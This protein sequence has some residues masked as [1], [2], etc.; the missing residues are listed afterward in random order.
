MTWNSHIG[1]RQES[2]L[3]SAPHSNMKGRRGHGS[4]LRAFY[5][6]PSR[7]CR[8]IRFPEP[9]PLG[10]FSAPMS[11]SP[12][13]TTGARLDFQTICS[14]PRVF[15]G[16]SHGQLPVPWPLEQASVVSSHVLTYGEEHVHLPAAAAPGLSGTLQRAWH[17][18]GGP[19]RPTPGEHL[20]ERGRRIS[21]LG[22][23]RRGSFR[24][25]VC[26]P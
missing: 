13:R 14:A 10:V 6:N 7:R 9:G 15:Q 16:G 2:G 22:L 5:P 23:S 4:Q 25:A 17:L 19:T 20:M 21:E 1:P 3:W 11:R 12:P 8:G 26:L 24:T 18:L